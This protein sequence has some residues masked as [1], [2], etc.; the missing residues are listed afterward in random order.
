MELM[1]RTCLISFGRAIRIRHA[2]GG[3]AIPSLWLDT[4]KF[5][6]HQDCA[7]IHVRSGALARSGKIANTE[8]ETSSGQKSNHQ[9]F[10]KITFT[11]F[12]GIFFYS[13]TTKS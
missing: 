9:Q 12:Q 6:Y 13:I 5:A 8:Q 2:S 11:A 3:I 7:R 4:K 1:R 10:I